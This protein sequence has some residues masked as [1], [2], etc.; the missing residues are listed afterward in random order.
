M[1][2]TNKPKTRTQQTISI[3]EL[4]STAEM[5]RAFSRRERTVERPPAALSRNYSVGYGKALPPKSG[6]GLGR[7]MS[8]RDKFVKAITNPDSIFRH[9]P[10]SPPP[11]S[12][13]VAISRERVK[14]T[15]Q[16]ENG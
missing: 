14:H 16:Y 5:R 4:P 3:S 13:Y 6:G 11:E 10:S 1:D 7:S 12:K 8:R 2:S 9:D 15:E